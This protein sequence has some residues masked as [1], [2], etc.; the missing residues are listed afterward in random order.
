MILYEILGIYVSATFMEKEVDEY[1]IGKR[2]LAMIIGA[3]PDHFRQDDIDV[4]I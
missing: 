2:H 4:S 1:Q 3:D